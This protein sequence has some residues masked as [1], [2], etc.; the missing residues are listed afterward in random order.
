MD[1]KI[2]FEKRIKHRKIDGARYECWEILVKINGEFFNQD[3]VTPNAKRTQKKIHKRYWNTI[4]KFYLDGCTMVVRLS[5]LHF[6][7]DDV[8]KYLFAKDSRRDNMILHYLRWVVQEDGT[9]LKDRFALFECRGRGEFKKFFDEFWFALG[10][11]LRFEGILLNP[12]RA[13]DIEKWSRRTDNQRTYDALIRM[14]ELIFDNQH[15]GFHFRVI[16][17]EKYSKLINNVLRRTLQ[18]LRP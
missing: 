8:K 6:N 12:E 18:G 11:E 17:R 14:S 7:L 1:S 10:F 3:A 5:G 9:L 16:S 15:N 13:L 2:E 4:N